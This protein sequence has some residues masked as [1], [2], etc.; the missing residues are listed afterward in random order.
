M[1]ARGTFSI[2]LV[3]HY[4]RGNPS[5]L[6]G[7]LYLRHFVI[8][9]CELIFDTVGLAIEGIYCPDEHII[10]DIVQVPTEAQPRPCHGDM[11][12]STFALCFD[13]QLSPSDILSVPRGERRQEL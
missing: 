5:C 4:D 13:E 1:F 9:T 11:V 7:T 6:V 2:V 10:G 8:R 12:G 3:A